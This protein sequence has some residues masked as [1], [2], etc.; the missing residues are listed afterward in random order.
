MPYCPSADERS[1]VPALL[2]GPETVM[3]ASTGAAWGAHAAAK[4]G[5]KAGTREL[6]RPFPIIGRPRP[7]RS[8]AMFADVAESGDGRDN[9][10]Q[11][12]R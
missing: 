2:V 4:D 1:I 7:V 12:H 3:I 5:T 10:F 8:V 11:D 9:R 6:L